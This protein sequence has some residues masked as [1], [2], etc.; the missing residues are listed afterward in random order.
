MKKREKSVCLG[1][2][3]P[4]KDAVE[5]ARV[6]PVPL[7]VTSCSAV[8]CIIAKKRH[9]PVCGRGWLWVDEEVHH[10]DFDLIS[11]PD[12]SIVVHNNNKIKTPRA[13]VPITPSP[14]SPPPFPGLTPIAISFI[15]LL[16]PFFVHSL[17]SDAPRCRCSK[18]TSNQR[19]I[20][21]A[22]TSFL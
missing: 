1:R 5:D 9:G 7:R 8:F 22:S 6:R 12:R 16:F 19:A 15:S 18:T 2:N 17:S 10:L 14:P 3:I 11:P 4:E 21:V 20:L 13:P